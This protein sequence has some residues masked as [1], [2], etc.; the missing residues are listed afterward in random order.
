MAHDQFYNWLVA[1]AVTGAVG[2]SWY[3]TRN[4]PN[5]VKT[6][7]YATSSSD[8]GVTF[9]ADTR[10]TTV[11]SD[12]SAANPCAQAH[13]QYGD[14][15]GIAALGGSIHPVW[16]DARFDCTVDSATGST[17]GEEVFTATIAAT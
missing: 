5:N 6:D 8:G 11:E 17:L 1:D 2:L 10:V 16:T 15:E 14:Y 4:D 7:V 12:E 13:D 9:A 3:D